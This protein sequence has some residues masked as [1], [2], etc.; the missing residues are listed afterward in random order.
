ML[1]NNNH[2]IIPFVSVLQKAGGLRATSSC[3]IP[4]L[5]HWNVYCKGQL[6]GYTGPQKVYHIWC[7]FY[8][9]ILSVINKKPIF[10]LSQPVKTD[11]ACGSETD[12]IPLTFNLHIVRPTWQIPSLLNS[13]VI[14]ILLKCLNGNSSMSKKQFLEMLG[15]PIGSGGKG[16][17]L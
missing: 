7:A 2:W 8:H 4:F 17:F 13:L 16:H 3:F 12:W 14:W 10:F 11:L 5:N 6:A 15:S 1:P 9:G